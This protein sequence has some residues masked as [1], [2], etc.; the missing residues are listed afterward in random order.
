MPPNGSRLSCSALVKDQMPP[1]CAASFK[2]LLGGWLVELVY[3]R[4]ALGT[5]DNRRAPRHLNDRVTDAVAKACLSKDK[6]VHGRDARKREQ[7]EDGRETDGDDDRKESTTDVGMQ[8]EATSLLSD[9]GS[10][11]DVD[12]SEPFESRPSDESKKI[13]VHTILKEQCRS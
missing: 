3:R 12:G 7:R 1:T 5:T 11:S 10:L 9:S 2:R 4:P 13:R 8:T 6:L